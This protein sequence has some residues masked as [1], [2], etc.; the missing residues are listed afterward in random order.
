[1]REL[2]HHF[3]RLDSRL[4]EYDRDLEGGRISDL[5]LMVEDRIKS[6]SSD[7]AETIK[8]IRSELAEQIEVA[9]AAP[10]AA[11][12]EINNAVSEMHKRMKRA[13]KRQTESIEAIGE[14]FARLTE[15]LDRR[16]RQIEQRNDSDLGSSVREQIESLANNF[17]KRIV[18][19][20]RLRIRLKQPRCVH[21]C[22]R[23]QIPVG[24]SEHILPRGTEGLAEELARFGIRRKGPWSGQH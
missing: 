12:A 15:A 19:L 7:L 23:H 14:E 18:E 17:H 22:Q 4:E 11:F 16:V 13:E 10:N 5:K 9:S 8:E 20:E 21:E 1:M 3:N 24:A 6:A 2:E